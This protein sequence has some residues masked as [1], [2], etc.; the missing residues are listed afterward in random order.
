MKVIAKYATSG[1]SKGMGNHTLKSIISILGKAITQEIC[2]W[3]VGTVIINMNMQMLKKYSM[4][5]NGLSGYLSTGIYTL[6]TIFYCAEKQKA[7]SNDFSFKAAKELSSR[8]KGGDNRLSVMV[9]TG[10]LWQEHNVTCVLV[11]RRNDLTISPPQTPSQEADR[12]KGDCLCLD[13]LCIY[14]IAVM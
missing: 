6:S 2:W 5:T 13:T 8:R 9:K 1:F 11:S 3:S 4:R 7:F 10:G 12:W 14:T